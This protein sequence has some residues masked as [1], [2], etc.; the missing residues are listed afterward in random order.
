MKK[1]TGLINETFPDLIWQDLIIKGPKKHSFEILHCSRWERNSYK[2]C[3]SDKIV[4]H[5]RFNIA[6]KSVFLSDLQNIILFAWSLKT[7]RSTLRHLKHLYYEILPYVYK[8]R[9]L[10]AKN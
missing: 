4:F 8:T 2:K 9:V 6:K 1:N 10:L 5:H 7:S 3:R